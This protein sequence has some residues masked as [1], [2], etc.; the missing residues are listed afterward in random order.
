MFK[1]YTLVVVVTAYTLRYVCDLPLSSWRFFSALA[2]FCL[3]FGSV[4]VFAEKIVVKRWRATATAV[5]KES[6]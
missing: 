5:R 3:L 1:L 6:R 2:I 4:T